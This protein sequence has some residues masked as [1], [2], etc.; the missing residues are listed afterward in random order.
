MTLYYQLH[1]HVSCICSN[2]CCEIIYAAVRCFVLNIYVTTFFLIKCHVFPRGDSDGVA[3][4]RLLGVS[5]HCVLK[6]QQEIEGLTER[7]GF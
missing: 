6:E 1:K 3:Y 2:G 4:T 5:Q 7:E